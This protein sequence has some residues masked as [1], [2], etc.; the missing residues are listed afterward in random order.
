M[1]ERGFIVEPMR[2]T[3]GGRG[4]RYW[5]QSECDE[6]VRLANRYGIGPVGE[7]HLHALA[8]EHVKLRD[9]ANGG[10]VIKR[11]NWGGKGQ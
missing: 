11:S 10:T 9:K 2:A 5:W 7:T 3:L 1:I 4:V 8:L 6:I